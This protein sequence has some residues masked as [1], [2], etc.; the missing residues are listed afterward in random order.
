MKYSL[1]LSSLVIAT[2]L[3]ADMI[4]QKVE[5]A[6]PVAPVGDEKMGIPPVASET[7]SII[8]NPI[9]EVVIKNEKPFEVMVNNFPKPATIQKVQLETNTTIKLDDVIPV[10]VKLVGPIRLIEPERS[11]LSSLNSAKQ[12][13]IT[14]SAILLGELSTETQNISVYRVS[15]KSDEGEKAGLKIHFTADK[16]IEIAKD[17]K[18]L[19]E[20]EIYMDNEEAEKFQKAL[21][22]M[23]SLSSG[24]IE[25]RDFKL[26][27]NGLADFRLS[28][29]TVKKMFGSSRDIE[30]S[31]V[32]GKNEKY[33]SEALMGLKEL[34]E[35]Q[36]ILSKVKTTPVS[37]L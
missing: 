24:T 14:E 9:Q 28:L 7:P 18:I 12:L 26:S 13:L 30:V 15:V 32:I 27:Y 21:A 3:A 5:G 22:K 4:P 36:T 35:F 11:Q 37:S 29:Y 17:Q 33:S 2:T 16:K 23:V 25:N 34:T 6:V 31:M 8:A 10:Q 1:L 20:N 19:I